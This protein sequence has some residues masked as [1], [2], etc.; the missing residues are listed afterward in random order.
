M[1]APTRVPHCRSK[2]TACPSYGRLLDFE[3]RWPWT[4]GAAPPWWCPPLVSALGD[5][6]STRNRDLVARGERF[7]KEIYSAAGLWDRNETNPWSSV[8]SQE[9]VELPI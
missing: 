9:Q 3:P 6:Q 7:T 1:I 5:K 4:N 2:H 8:P